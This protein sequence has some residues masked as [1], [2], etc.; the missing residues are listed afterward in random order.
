LEEFTAEHLAGCFDR[1]ERELGIA[2]AKFAVMSRSNTL[3]HELLER[4]GKHGAPLRR[5]A[6][7]CEGCGMC[8]YGCTSGAKRGMARSYIPKAVAAGATVV[9]HARARQI[10]L[11]LRG[12]AAGVDAEA[13]DA[14][15]HPTG[16]RIRVD[17][18]KVIVAC[19]TFLSPALLHANKLARGNR[20]LGRHLTIHPASKVSAEFDEVINSWNGIPQA[21]E[22]AGLHDDGILF[23]G[24]SMPP[25]L[26]AIVPLHGARLAQYIANYRHVASFGFMIRDSAEGRMVRIPFGPYQFL[27]ALNR[28][29][30]RRIRTAI[31]FLA[32]LFLRGCA[33]VAY[34]MVHHADNVFTT[35]EDVDRFEAAELAPGDIECMAFHPLG[36][37]RMAGMPDLGVC[38]AYHQV[39][40]APGLYVCDGSVVPTPLGVNP[41]QTIMGLATRLA[42]HLLGQPLR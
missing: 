11:N 34:A 24:I 5:N 32:R 35:L 3:V 12:A 37:C 19:G 8:C 2:P 10:R 16:R 26:G 39:F 1:V 28:A 13:V 17:A 18:P 4:E 31:A 20:H 22:Y 7:D 27:Y 30:A 23:E 36:T 25:D 21:Y 29:D 40:G 9:L 42:G 15:F 6:P 41:Q 38:D 14:A 33:R